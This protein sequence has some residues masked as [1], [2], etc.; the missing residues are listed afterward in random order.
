MFCFSFRN[1][2]FIQGG[3]FCES[4]TVLCSHQLIFLVAS[5]TLYSSN[6]FSNPSNRCQHIMFPLCHFSLSSH[7]VHQ[8]M[9]GNIVCRPRKSSNLTL[10]QLTCHFWPQENHIITRWHE[11]PGILSSSISECLSHFKKQPL[12]QLPP[13]RKW[14][15]WKLPGSQERVNICS[16]L[17]KC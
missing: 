8:R 4:H 13:P 9:R 16:V 14:R 15:S 17:S 10:P 5:N 6:Q 3:H 1:E 11:W 7:I 2:H 12:A